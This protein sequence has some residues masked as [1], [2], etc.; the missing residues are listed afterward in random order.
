MTDVSELG[1]ERESLTSSLALVSRS[2]RRVK[3]TSRHVKP[4]S[5]VVGASP[6]RDGTWPGPCPA[7]WPQASLR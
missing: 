5:C 2:R 1:M 7:S 4:C 3:V 6:R